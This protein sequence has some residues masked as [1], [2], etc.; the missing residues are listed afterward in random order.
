MAPEKIN[1][2]NN[3]RP[4]GAAPRPILVRPHSVIE[5]HRI[6][7]NRHVLPRPV[8]VSTDKTVEERLHLKSLIDQVNAHNAANPDN[9]KK[10]KYINGVPTIVD[11]NPSQRSQEN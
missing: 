7:R 10:K 4:T 8:E 9:K 6:L 11:D 5:V 2:G 3:C 1:L